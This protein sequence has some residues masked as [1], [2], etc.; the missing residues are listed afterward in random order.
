MNNR[1]QSHFF[2]GPFAPLS[3][4]SAAG[5]IIIS[6][7]RLAHAVFTAGAL[8]WVY[9]VT[10]LI[11]FAAHK[12]LPIKGKKIILLFLTSFSL[13]L[14]IFLISLINPLFLTGAWF[15]LI[16][17]CPCCISSGLYEEKETIEIGD[18]LLRV[19]LE[20]LVLGLLVIA[21]SLIR[22]PLGFGSLSLPG[23][24][25]GI[26]E[27]FAVNDGEGFLPIHVLSIPAG[28]FLI[29]GLLTAVFRY[30]KDQYIGQNTEQDTGQNTGEK[31]GEA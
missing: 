11:Y 29:L 1:M 10:A 7:S 25:F 3:T 17:V 14:Y 19:S 8:V 26:I 27:F 6:S 4:L 13:S 30:F 16:F 15:L 28:G 18:I 31:E 23:G 5:L 2:W 21:I 12:L 22:E 9:A 24:A 20:A